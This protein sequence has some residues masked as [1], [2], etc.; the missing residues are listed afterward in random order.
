MDE[1]VTGA[2]TELATYLA[3]SG[4]DLPQNGRNKPE[5]AAGC[6]I[7]R[8]EALGRGSISGGIYGSEL[9]E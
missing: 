7:Q 5:G 2:K 8:L 3:E 9:S 4:R 6:R 1:A